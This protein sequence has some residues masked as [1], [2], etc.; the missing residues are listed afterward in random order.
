MDCGAD[1]E[2]RRP[3]DQSSAVFGPCKKGHVAALRVLLAAGVKVNVTMRSGMTPLCVAAWA[4]HADAVRHLSAADADLEALTASGSTPLMAAT[5]RGHADALLALLEQGARPDAPNYAGATPLEMGRQGNRT[6]TCAILEHALAL[7]ARWQSR[8]GIL[9]LRLARDAGRADVVTGTVD[10]LRRWGAR[11][12]P[13]RMA[14]RSRRSGR[15]A[16]SL[17]AAYVASPAAADAGSGGVV[18]EAVD[19]PMPRDDGPAAGSGLPRA[20]TAAASVEADAAP[21]SAKVAPAKKGPLRISSSAPT[22]RGVRAVTMAAGAMTPALSTLD[23]VP[24]TRAAGHGHDVMQKVAPHLRIPPA[25][26]AAS[27]MAMGTRRAR[28]AT[29]AGCGGTAV[30]AG[31]GLGA[32]AARAALL[33]PDT[34]KGPAGDGSSGGESDDDGQGHAQCVVPARTYS[35]RR[36]KRRRVSYRQQGGDG[37]QGSRRGSSSSV[38]LDQCM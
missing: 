18:V 32:R 31:S 34:G 10:V 25:A 7:R 12:T 1:L 6:E 22:A 20:D 2:V 15:G 37:S 35:L 4:G 19:E 21:V 9:L 38:D 8:R 30:V 16:R 23:P 11:M 24:N 17:R 27:S 29:G 3:D 14:R 33:V 13:R 28:V 5:A 26:V 36:S